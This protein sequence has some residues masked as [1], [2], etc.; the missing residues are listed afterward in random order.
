MSERTKSIWQKLFLLLLFVCLAFLLFRESKK[1]SATLENALPHTN[2][3]AVTASYESGF[4]DTELSVKLDTH[5]EVPVGARIRYTL[6]GD[7]PSGKS[8]VYT[9]PIRIEMP[10]EGAS[11]VPLKAKIFYQDEVSGIYSWTYVLGKNAAGE[12][13]L[14]VISITSGYRGLYSYESGILVDGI[15]KDMARAMGRSA[16][17]VGNAFQRGPDWIRSSHV[18]MFSPEGKLLFDQ[19]AGLMISGGSSRVRKI[20]SFKI[21]AGAPYDSQ[22][23]RFRLNLFQDTESDAY[24]YVNEFKSLKLRTTDINNRSF[25]AELGEELA[26]QSGYAGYQFSEPAILYL[27]GSFYSIVDLQPSISDS[28]LARRYSVPD[29]RFI[30]KYKKTEK[31]VFD[32]FGITHYLKA[33]L[34]VKENREALEKLVDMDDYLLYCAIQVLLNNTDWPGNNFEAWRY[35]SA[36][37][38]GNRFTDG[39]VRFLMYDL[40]FIYSR[41]FVKED[42]RGND[43]FVNLMENEYFASQSLFSNVMKVKRYRDRFV[44]IVTD[45]LNT[46]FESSS[47]K[48]L[49]EK[50]YIRKRAEI[51]KNWGSEFDEAALLFIKSAEETADKRAEEMARNFSSYFGLEET[52]SLRLSADE[53]VTVSWNNMSLTGNDGY[54]CDYLKDVRI[55]YRTSVSPGYRFKYWLVNGEKVKDKVLKI[56]GNEAEEGIVAVEAV[57][58]RVTGPLLLI[59]EVSAKSSSDWIRLL[60]AGTEEVSLS[61]YCISDSVTEPEKYSL[62]EKTLAAGESVIINGDKNYYAVGEYI[63]NF[64]L[65]RGETLCLYNRTSGEMEKLKIPRMNAFETYGRSASLDRFVF[66]NNLDEIRKNITEN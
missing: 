41:D 56:N 44:T 4:Y 65:R 60:N 58:E 48:A 14:P 52:Y 64:N 57:A 42:E 53:G 23:E 46:S 3:R 62:P 22:H 2:G 61:D 28:Y 32:A 51:L 45:L 18:T 50:I 26:K 5:I 35:Y 6:N 39:K 9:E 29:S 47:V 17:S 54:S 63:C 19:D 55:S 40:D 30:L 1:E 24:S 8:S 36:G 66:Y 11:V 25:S 15:T 12:F 49:M 21:T 38:D 13:S 43:E 16:Y 33:D 10:K 34:S 37:L 59:A 31:N 20:K 7:D 27:N